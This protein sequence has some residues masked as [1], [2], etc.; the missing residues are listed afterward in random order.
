MVYVCSRLPGS[1]KANTSPPE[2]SPPPKRPDPEV[3]PWQ[4]HAIGRF[5]SRGQ[6]AS[7]VPKM[8]ESS[9]FLKQVRILPKGIPTH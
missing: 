7:K 9:P 3:L 5:L 8:E 1:R 2:T 6:P 4:A